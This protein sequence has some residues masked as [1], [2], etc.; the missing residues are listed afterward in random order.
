[1]SD[2]RAP[3]RGRPQRRTVS[4]PPGGAD[5]AVLAPKAS[6][7]PWDP[8]SPDVLHWTGAGDR[9][10]VELL[11]EAL[12]DGPVGG[13]WDSGFPAYVWHRDGDDVHEFRLTGRLTGQ[14]T[15][16]PLHPSEWPEGL[17]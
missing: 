7:T 3:E 9:A 13:P 14:Y 8:P 4:E 5:R 1:M 16:Y 17:G 12:A 6:F 15:G 2:I 10:P 11:R